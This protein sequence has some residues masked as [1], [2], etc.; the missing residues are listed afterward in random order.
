MENKE[1]IG[2]IVGQFGRTFGEAVQ[3]IAA[4]HNMPKGSLRLFPYLDVNKDVEIT[5]KDLCE[6]AHCK[7]STISVL[8]DELERDGYLLKSKSKTDSRKT[9]IK[10]TEKGTKTAHQ[11][12]GILDSLDSKIENALTKEEQETIISCIE[13]LIKVIQEEAQ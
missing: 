11:L 8:I 7:A 12:K 1:N 4:K 6:H 5:Q 9:I 10:L 3:K 13:R 2:F